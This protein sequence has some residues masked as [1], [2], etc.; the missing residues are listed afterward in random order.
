MAE[1]FRWAI[2]AGRLAWEAGIMAEQEMAVAT[3]PVTGRPFVLG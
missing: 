3:T 1:A 2:Y